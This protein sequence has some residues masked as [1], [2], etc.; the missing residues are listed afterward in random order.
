MVERLRL[1]ILPQPDDST[2]GPTCLQAVYR[3]FGD[4]YPLDELIAQTPRLKNGG[5]LAVLLGTHALQRGYRATLYT[6]DLHVFDPTWFQCRQRTSTATY[7]GDAVV[8]LIEKLAAEMQAKESEK[9]RMACEAYAEFLTHGGRIRM[10]DLT[11]KLIRDQLKRGMPI[12]TGLSSSYLYQHVR[13]FGPDCVDDDIKGTPQGH[14]VVLCGYDPDEQ[15]VDVADPYLKNP[16]GVQHHYHVRLERLICAILLGV[17][18]YDAN[19]LF[20]EPQSADFQPSL[21]LA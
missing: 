12:L 1:D 20:I 5:T 9:T 18:T 10:R 16:L 21:Y 15:M 3:Y 6:Y 4:E 14:F 8:P 7:K 2:C 19:L 17:I 13:E 11:A